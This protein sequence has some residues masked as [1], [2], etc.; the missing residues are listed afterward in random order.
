MMES[1]FN[2]LSR[3]RSHDGVRFHHDQNVHIVSGE[4]SVCLLKG[5]SG[6]DMNSRRRHEIFRRFH[7]IDS[8]FQHG[9][10]F[11][12]HLDQGLVFDRRRCRGSMPSAVKNGGDVSD[13]DLGQTAACHQINAI[14]HH[15]EGEN[16]V[17]V[18]H[19]AQF[20]DQEG[21]VRHIGFRRDP[22]YNYVYAIY[23]MVDDIFYH[24]VKKVNLFRT[25][26][27]AHHVGDQIQIG[28][29]GKQVGGS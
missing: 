13:V 16:D 12:F 5:D 10:Q 11:F 22:G 8:L 7:R 3:D 23:G 18:F 17:E 14:F 24:V 26:F 25:H 20:V 1:L 9:K 4:D 21:K 15:P 2:D 29:F 6:S 27:P 28:T 19:V